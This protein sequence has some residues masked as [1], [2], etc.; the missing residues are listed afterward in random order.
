MRISRILGAGALGLSLAAAAPSAKAAEI[1]LWSHWADHQT[2]VAFVEEAA[3]RF[4]KNNPDHTVK[5]SWYQKNPLYAALKASMQAGTAPDVFYCEPSQTEY[6]DNDLIMPLDDHLNWDNIE[7]WARDSWTFD[8]K[9]Y[10]LPLE[11]FT[12]ELYYNTD[13]MKELGVD[14]GGDK[15]I[16]HAAFMDVIK[17]ARAAGVTPIVQGVGDRP[18]PGAYFTHEMIL[19]KIGSED[20]GKLWSG[21]V[22]FSD[23][24]VVEVFNYVKSLVDAGAYPKSFS[25]LKL[26]ESHYYFH[27][28]PGGLMFPMGSWYTSRAFNPPEQGGQ[29]EDFPL[30]IMKMPVPDGADCP[31][32]KTSAIGGSF[33]I[34][35]GS[36][37]PELAVALLN[38]MATV[39][40]GTKWL[41]DILVQTG[42]KSD[43]SKIT[44]QYKPY[45]EELQTINAD[46]KFFTG[47]P[48]HHIKGQC[49]ETF[50]QVMNG[51]FPA[52]QIGVDQ[53]V[54]MMDQACSS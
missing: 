9:S 44:G 24:R 15:Q 49:A 50:K 37:N 6:I 33:C 8:G 45:F 31:E 35:S 25:T 30:G 22:K 39:D 5:I 3:K 11:A 28:K 47:I 51:A 53:T 38:E 19:K 7:Q 46:A 32:C 42:V 1:T 27:T 26:G 2:K 13:K 54:Q 14:L 23:P 20:Y 43:A 18:Y 36:D 41:A 34:N 16:D 10:A 17:K 29:P 12:V 21:E 48:L 4:E 40:M 52:G